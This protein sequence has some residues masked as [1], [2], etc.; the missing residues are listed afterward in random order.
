MADGDVER[1]EEGEEVDRFWTGVNG[2]VWEVAEDEG[3]AE[4]GDEDPAALGE[5]V[6]G[7]EGV[8]VFE[9]GFCG[10][11]GG[12]VEVVEAAVEVVCYQGRFWE[13]GVFERDVARA[14][15][16]DYSGD[17][18]VLPELHVEFEQ[19]VGEIKHSCFLAQLRGAGGVKRRALSERG[20]ER[21]DNSIK[22]ASGVRAVDII[23]SMIAV[24]GGVECIAS[25]T[26]DRLREDPAAG[27][28]ERCRQCA[29]HRQ[30]HRLSQG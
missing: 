24:V 25:R 10:E 29:S 2:G 12:V 4:E 21:L 6:F 13:V 27:C 20:V 28:V 3:D 26:P 23:R 30:E 7:A 14:E 9:G 8:G 5:E 19:T 11:E 17:K 16:V 22:K 15:V 18:S 1:G